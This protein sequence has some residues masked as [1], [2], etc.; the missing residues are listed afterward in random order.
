[1]ILVFRGEFREG[2]IYLGVVGIKEIFEILGMDKIVGN[3]ID[4]KIKEISKIF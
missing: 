3:S 4:E 2:Y 1:M